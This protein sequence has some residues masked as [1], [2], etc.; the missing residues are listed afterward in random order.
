ML[1]N[2]HAFIGH[3]AYF[4]TQLLLK[5]LRVKVYCHPLTNPHQQYVYGFWH[6]KQFTPITVMPTYRNAKHACLVSASGDGEILATWLKDLGYYVVRG[7][8]SRKA[9]S[10]VVKLLSC[11]KKGYSL[12]IAADG[13]RGPRYQAKSG[14]AFL[15]KKA[16]LNMVPMGVAFS[17]KY[18]FK[19]SWDQ[20]QLPY[21]FSQVILYLGEPVCF[22]ENEADIKIMNQQVEKQIHAA[23]A[24]AQSFLEKRKQ[25]SVASNKIS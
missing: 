18:Q 19:K 1:K 20:Y 14:I 17:K 7:S 11:A 5:T 4:L 22:H 23:E 15:A 21:P 9:I 13:P 2:K 10:S 24:M 6:G 8:S 3:I 25:T 16:Q 12:G